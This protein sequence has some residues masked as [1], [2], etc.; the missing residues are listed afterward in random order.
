MVLALRGLGHGVV[1]VP[2]DVLPATAL[3]P[4]DR[5]GSDHD[6]RRLRSARELPPP[7]FDEDAVGHLT[8]RRQ[9][10]GVARDVTRTWHE[11]RRHPV[12]SFTAFRPAAFAAAPA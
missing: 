5:G 7:A 9:E 12:P 8:G 6:L 3:A 10:G 1:A 4:E 11:L 2:M